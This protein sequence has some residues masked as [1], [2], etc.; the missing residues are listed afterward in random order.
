MPLALNRKR[1][2]TMEEFKNKQEV[3]R[4]KLNT[5]D[6]I[7]AVDLTE[8]KR[9]TVSESKLPALDESLTAI[10]ADQE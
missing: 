2:S 7:D 4:S 5:S 3:T 10:S 1:K 9:S 6:Q 8:A